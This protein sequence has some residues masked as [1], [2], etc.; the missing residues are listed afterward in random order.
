MSFPVEDRATIFEYA[1]TH[2]K[3]SVYESKFMQNKLKRICDGLSEVFAP[4]DGDYIW[5]QYLG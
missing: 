5:E 4:E 2:G 1:V 3:D